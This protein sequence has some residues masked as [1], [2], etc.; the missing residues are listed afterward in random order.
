M[1]NA[2]IT[3][4]AVLVLAMGG[5]LVYDKIIDK[6][7]KIVENKDE[8]TKKNVIAAIDEKEIADNLFYKISNIETCISH[9]FDFSGKTKLT[10]SELP[11]GYISSL[12]AN[13]L[14]DSNEFE[15]IDEKLY[16]SEDNSWEIYLPIYSVSIKGYEEAYKRVFGVNSTVKLPQSFIMPVSNFLQHHFD[17]TLE[18]ENY[19]GEIFNSDCGGS[20]GEYILKSY[21]KDGDKFYLM[22]YYVYP[23]GDSAYYSPSYTFENKYTKEELNLHEDELIQYK[24]NF[25]LENENYILDSVELVN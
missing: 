3:V 19:I 14:M 8:E 16:L 25:I 6:D 22:V 7:D 24:Y 18:N 11:N 15:Y 10:Y 4:L 23:F 5:Y 1:K 12:V 9:E 21:K 2:V 17:F 20:H 13:E